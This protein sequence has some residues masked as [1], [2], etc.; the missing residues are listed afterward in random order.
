MSRNTSRI[1]IEQLHLF[2]IQSTGPAWE[3]LPAPTQ[4][5]IVRLLARLMLL[6]RNSDPVRSARGEVGANE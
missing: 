2:R 6:M 1:R 4:Q 3:N 5:E